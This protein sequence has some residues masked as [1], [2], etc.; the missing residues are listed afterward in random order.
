MTYNSEVGTASGTL[1]ISWAGGVS[2]DV[3]LT[4]TGP[5][6]VGEVIFTETAKVG[7]SST[8]TYA[9]T[10]PAG[11]YSVSVVVVGGGASLRGANLAWKNNIPVVPGTTYDVVVGRGAK[12]GNNAQNG[13]PSHFIS[14]ATVMASGGQPSGTLVGDG[15]GTGGN[16]Y[17]AGG[18]AGGYS[19]SGGFGKG[20]GQGSGG[21][22]TGGGGGG[23]GVNSNGYGGSGGGVGLYGEGASGAAGTASVPGGRGGSSGSNGTT[24]GGGA[25]Y[26]GGGTYDGSGYASGGNGAVRIIWGPGRSFPNNAS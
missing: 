11:V 1:N 15:G 16:G 4:A 18:G 19:G 8:T 13:G 12:A 21:V 24:N 17:R 2:L 14:Q 5:Q 7:A 3:A 6:A 10:A 20:T 9:W 22:G 25:N 26:G 23:G